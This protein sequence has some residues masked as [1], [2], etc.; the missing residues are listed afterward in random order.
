[1]PQQPM[2][3]IHVWEEYSG[4]R[5]KKREVLLDQTLLKG[6]AVDQVRLCSYHQSGA[7]TESI[8]FVCKGI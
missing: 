1:M 4:L 7:F 8:P 6:K 5:K 2:F 3:R